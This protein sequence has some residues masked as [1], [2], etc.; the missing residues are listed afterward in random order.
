MT[1]FTRVEADAFVCAYLGK[2]PNE[3]TF[4]AARRVLDHWQET[5]LR[6]RV[7][8]SRLLKPGDPWQA[9]QDCV[10]LIRG[11]TS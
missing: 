7:I 5:P 3:T 11:W 8:A 6:V 4:D 1:K 10:T 9:I 2:R